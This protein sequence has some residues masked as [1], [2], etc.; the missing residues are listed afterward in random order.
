[1][2]PNLRLKRH[3]AASRSIPAVGPVFAAEMRRV[4]SEIKADDLLVIYFAGRALIDKNG[5]ASWM[6]YAPGKVETIAAQ[7][8][9]DFIARARAKYTVVIM[10]CAKD[11]FDKYIPTG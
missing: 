5:T 3:P 10:D 6:L 8:I 4:L 11:T 7:E 2:T 1:M 9:A